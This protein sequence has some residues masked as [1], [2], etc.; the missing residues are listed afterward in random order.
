L[1]QH[2]GYIAATTAAVWSSEAARASRRNLDDDTARDTRITG[3]S[4]TA[5]ASVRSDEPP[6][7]NY[8]NDRSHQHRRKACSDRAF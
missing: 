8:P 1:G 3:N 2:L 5:A 7:S 6:Q 4:C